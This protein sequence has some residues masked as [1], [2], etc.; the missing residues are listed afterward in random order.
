M[1]ILRD[2][3]LEEAVMNLLHI[4]LRTSLL[5]HFACGK[6]QRML[7]WLRDILSAVLTT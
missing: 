4:H 5:Y 7:F 2:D 3:G 1:R 6:T